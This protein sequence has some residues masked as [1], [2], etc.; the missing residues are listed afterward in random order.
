LTYIKNNYNVST[1]INIVDSR[2]IKLSPT[3]I[4]KK[5]KFSKENKTFFHSQMK[6]GFL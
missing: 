2:Q 5:N 1:F 3:E 6:K 4:V